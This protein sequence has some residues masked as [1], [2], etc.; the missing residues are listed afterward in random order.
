MI[1]DEEIWTDIRRLKSLRESGTSY[2]EIA[3]EC[4]V[5]YRTVKKYLA[6]GHVSR[7]DAAVG[8]HAGGPGADH[9]DAAG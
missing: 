6:A 7:G 1:L 3:R 5:D 4:G 2:A 9:R 8:D